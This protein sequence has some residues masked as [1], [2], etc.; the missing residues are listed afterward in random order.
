MRS[1]VLAI[2]V[3]VVVPLAALGV[4][5]ARGGDSAHKP[6]RLPILASGGTGAQGGA[7]L[8]VAREDAAL[9]P[10]GG[11]VYKAGA[12]LPTLDGSARAYKLSRDGV[13]EQLRRLT[14]ALVG[15]D[16]TSSDPSALFVH[17]DD[18]T[19]W[20]FNRQTDGGVSSSG[21]A[22]ACPPDAAECPAPDTTIPQH[23]ADLPSQD[24]ARTIALDLLNQAGIDT[25]DVKV[26]VD[27]YIG[28]WSVRVDPIVDGVPTEGFATTIAV[29]PKGVI[30]YA[31]GVL[32]RP[33]V[34]DEYPLIGTSAAI[35]KLNNGDIF[36]GGGPR[37]LIAED[38]AV[39]TDARRTTTSASAN[40]SSGAGSPGAEPGSAGP[41][42]PAPSLP[43]CDGTGAPTT[44]PCGSPLEIPPVTDSLPPRPPPQEITLTGAERILV[45]APSY[46]GHES[47]L[48][49]AYRFT[50]G[51]GVG[52]SVLAID[53][54][55]LTPPPDQIPPGDGSVAPDQ[56]VTIE[57]QPATDPAVKEPS[58]GG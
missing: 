3:A 26:T 11:V 12:N 13:D 25:H 41:T 58:T 14:D 35:E 32:G 29:A 18:G 45:F 1:R 39:A 34:A 44:F 24:E 6:A 37:P 55:F 31:N 19:S 57:P 17:S 7:T 23:P 30:E 16:Q 8:G 33:E 27:D 51:E 52:P 28:V 10:Y 4:V 20:S 43:P 53:D 15:R 50:T 9:Y 54:S 38:T 5:I 48:V 2:V 40:P 21:T 36:F 56:P 47:W 49:P 46:D 22:V 42:D